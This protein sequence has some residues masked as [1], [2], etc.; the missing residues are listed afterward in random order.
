MGRKKGGRNQSTPDGAPAPRRGKR[1]SIR[2]EAVE[3]WPEER[4]ARL[5]AERREGRPPE[6]VLR[7]LPVAEALDRLA[8]QLQAYA[9]QGVREVLVV[10]GKGTNSPGGVPIIAPLA[11]KWCDEHP[12]VVES[13]SEAPQRWGGGGA[14]VVRLTKEAST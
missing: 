11:R 10:H 1:R 9:H 13:W 8:I 14:I 5:E 12:Q 7:K 2:Y 3:E 4:L 6:I